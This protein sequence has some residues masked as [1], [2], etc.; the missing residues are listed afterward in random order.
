MAQF[1][2]LL[3]TAERVYGLRDDNVFLTL[4]A[5]LALVRY[6]ALEAGRRLAA[7]GT[8]HMPEDVFHLT[9]EE[10]AAALESRH[11][12]TDVRDSALRQRD[13]RRRGRGRR[14]ARHTGLGGTRHRHRT[15]HPL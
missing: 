12:L 1:D 10:A 14:A 6:A 8:L 9:P 11:P 13:G 7:R 15:H 5:P 2:R 4:D 3:S